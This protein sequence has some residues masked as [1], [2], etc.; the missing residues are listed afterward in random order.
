MLLVT[1]LANMKSGKK[2]MVFKIFASLCLE[3]SSL[4]IGRVV[5]I[6]TS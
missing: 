4:S 2:M 3:E 1:N 5:V 6:S